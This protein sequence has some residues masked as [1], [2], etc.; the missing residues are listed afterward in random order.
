MSLRL[1]VCAFFLLSRMYSYFTICASAHIMLIQHSSVCAYGDCFLLLQ[2]GQANDAAIILTIRAFRGDAD[3]FAL[4]S[5]PAV[6]LGLGLSPKFESCPLF[7]DQAHGAAPWVGAGGPA[8]ARDF[9][10]HA[11]RVKTDPQYFFLHFQMNVGS[12]HRNRF[13]RVYGSGQGHFL[14]RPAGEVLYIREGLRT[15]S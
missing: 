6:F 12:I 7:R 8:M 2:Y 10:Q 4:K 9:L 15:C 5:S 1:C 13:R 11:F 14:P 3:C